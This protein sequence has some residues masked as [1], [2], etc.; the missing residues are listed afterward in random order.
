[1]I[2]K[3]SLRNTMMKSEKYQSVYKDFLSSADSSHKHLLLGA[4]HSLDKVYTFD[5]LGHIMVAVTSD[6]E[7]ETE[8]KKTFQNVLVFFGIIT[9]ALAKKGKM[10]F[11]YKALNSLISK[12]GIFIDV[13]KEQAHYESNSTE[14]ALNTHIIQ[15]MLGAGI[16]G[17]A[18]EIAKRTLNAIGNQITMSH[19]SGGAESE[20]AHILFVCESLMGMPIVS[21]SLYHTK[22]NQE[23]W[24]NETNCSKVSHSEVKFDYEADHYLFVNPEYIQ[25]FTK[26]FKESSEYTKLIDDIASRIE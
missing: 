21:V 22:A 14:V 25:K 6:G 11:D 13:N 12:S 20:V 17:G 9:A 16:T 26:D 24:K 10:L 8:I 19:S 7:I 3:T 18:L 23:Q 4:E 2:D 15:S 1:M 5:E